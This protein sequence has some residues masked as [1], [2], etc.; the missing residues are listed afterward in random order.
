MI[1]ERSASAFGKQLELRGSQ[2]DDAPGGFVEPIEAGVEAGVATRSVTGESEV[3]VESRVHAR[4]LAVQAEQEQLGRRL[5]E[6]EQGEQV[7]SRSGIVGAIDRLQQTGLTKRTLLTDGRDQL[8]GV[9]EPRWPGSAE[10][11][12]PQIDD[13]AQE[14]G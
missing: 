8:H 3:T 12:G 2:L 13:P 11:V 1:R 10:H 5:G 4:R 6:M 14:D 9:A 7:E